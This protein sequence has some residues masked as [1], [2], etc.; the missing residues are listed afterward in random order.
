MISFIA[1]IDQAVANIPQNTITD[2]N[3]QLYPLAIACR[4]GDLATVKK[5]LATDDEP[6]AMGNECY[7]FDIFLYGYLLQSFIDKFAWADKKYLLD[8]RTKE[9]I[10]FCSYVL[11]SKITQSRIKTNLIFI[12]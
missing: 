10:H 4:K 7:E 6:M 9:H 5:M 11:L 2:G 3:Y 8:I 12:C 1:G